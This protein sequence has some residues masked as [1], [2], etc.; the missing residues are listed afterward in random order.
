MQ[1]LAYGFPKLGKQREFKRLLE[2]FWKGGLSE[3]EFY[4]G[5]EDLKLKRAEVYQA[6]VDLFPSNEVSLYDFILDTAIMVGAI[7]GRFQPYQ[8]LKTYFEMAKGKQALEL[9]KWFN[10]NYHYL[11]PEIEKLEFSLLENFP[12]KDFL[13]YQKHG[14]DTFPKFIGPFTFLKLAKL[15]KPSAEGIK[16]EKINEPKVFEEALERLNL[17][18]QEVLKS[19]AKAGAKTVLIEEPGL[20]MDL[21]PW[22]WS[23]VKKSYEALSG[24]IDLWILTYYD[25]VSDYSSFIELPVK[26]LGMDLVSNQEN[27]ANL[28]VVGFP[29]DK[30]LIAGIINGRQVWKAKLEDKL[31]E[32]ENLLQFTQDLVIANSCPLFH[33]PV[34]LVGEDHLPAELTNKLSFAEEKLEELKLIKRGLEGDQE[35]LNLIA[36]IQRKV[37]IS[38]GQKEEINKRVSQLTEEDFTRGI[39]YSERIK[40]QQKRL[41]LP[42]FPT[43]TIG[44]FPQTEEVRAARAKFNKGEISFEEYQRFIKQKIAEVIKLQEDLGLDVLVHGEFERTDMVE[45]FAQKLEGIATTKQGW[46]LSYGSRVYRPPIIFGDVWR[47]AP[48]T[49]EE[50][51]YAQSLTSKPVKGM[52]TGPV[53]ILNWSFYR[54]DLPKEQIAY[55][56]ALALLDEVK[57]LERAGIKIIQI[58]EPAFREG[59]PIKRKDWDQYFSWA[60]KA[61]RLCAK[62]NPETQ[63]HTHMCYS[64]FNEIISYIA[65]MDFDVISIEASRS[66]GEIIEA[67]ETFP[68][69]DRQV[70]LGV[71]DIHSP[72][73]PTKEEMKEI[74]RRALRILPKELLWINPDCGLKTRRWEEVIPAL[75]NLVEVAKEL[76]QQF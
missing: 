22:E 18:Y 40:L 6:N 27:L 12:L 4:Q 51:N 55:Q 73:L 9:T 31:R 43:T 19:L 23:L 30:V 62:A 10:T 36:D 56:I 44:S 49:L 57:D 26:G 33:L 65:Q 54:E 39:P 64:E 28:K 69:W 20:V 70:G 74:V 52:L 35:A 50:I 46:V 11:V 48:M 47:K 37:Q 41:K 34:S 13:F 59:A 32:V 60:I 61:F 1:T 16:V 21:E 58:D 68:G 14:I 7:P 67:F 25:S 17:V 8:G 76:R 3:E 66:K 24:D 2:S 72:N 38:F 5:I 42:L 15:I 53:T 45:F 71:Y 75:R 63:I 29:K